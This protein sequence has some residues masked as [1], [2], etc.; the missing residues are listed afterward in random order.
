MFLHDYHEELKHAEVLADYLIMRG[1]TLS[2]TRH[3]IQLLKSEVWN[4]P[5]NAMD[6]VIQLEE[7]V[8]TSLLHLHQVAEESDAPL[9]EFIAG[10]YLNHQLEDLAEKRGLLTTLKR[11]SNGDGLQFYDK[12]ILDNY[13]DGERLWNTLLSKIWVDAL[14]PLMGFPWSFFRQQRS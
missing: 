5:I 4:S 7:T 11:L 8:T 2:G 14:T 9:A 1:G 6:E 12:R 13:K 10:K 3:P